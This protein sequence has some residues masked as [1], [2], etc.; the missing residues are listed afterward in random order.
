[1]LAEYRVGPSRH[2]N[3]PRCHHNLQFIRFCCPRSRFALLGTGG[4]EGAF[5]LVYIWRRLIAAAPALT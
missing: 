5:H 3:Q 4:V 2:W 1:M